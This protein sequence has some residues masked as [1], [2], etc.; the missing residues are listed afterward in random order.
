M[1]WLGDGGSGPFL[2]WMLFYSGIQ[3]LA[4]LHRN[5]GLLHC[6]L[7]ILVNVVTLPSSSPIIKFSF[8]ET[9]TRTQPAAAFSKKGALHVSFPG[10]EF[11][12][13][14]VNHLFPNSHDCRFPFAASDRHEGHGQVLVADGVLAI[15]VIRLF[16]PLG[17]L[18]PHI[19]ILFLGVTAHALAKH[20]RAVAS[21]S[22]PP[23]PAVS[24]KLGR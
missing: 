12:A 14:T 6:T 18:A 22:P 8:L 7:S 11:R 5:T 19:M 4:F 24:G 1:T 17:A 3:V 20:F 13:N 2:L 9:F 21:K 10:S 23:S 15:S 16:R